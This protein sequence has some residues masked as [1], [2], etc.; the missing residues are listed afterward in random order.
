M[1]ERLTATERAVLD[2]VGQG[3]TSRRIARELGIS[4]S[5]VDSHVRAALEK[6]G[7]RTRVQAAAL[8]ADQATGEAT[9][10]GLEEAEYHLL[11]LLAHGATLGEAAATL[12]ISRRTACRRLVMAK[13]K[14]RVPTTVEA[15]L[16]LARRDGVAAKTWLGASWLWLLDDPIGLLCAVPSLFPA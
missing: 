16:S 8:V 15:V 10:D 7:A 12:Y 4:A 6:L 5:T 3:L 2:L 13:A 1:V 14:L 11:R 9:R